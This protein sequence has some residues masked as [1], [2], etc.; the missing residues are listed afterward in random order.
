MRR[1]H[2]ALRAAALV[3]LTVYAPVATAQSGARW[4][5]VD[6]SRQ[7]RDT[8]PQRIRVQYAAGKLDVRGT[9]DPL[10]YAM[11]LRYDETRA[12]PLHRYDAEQRSALLGV[13]SLGRGLRAS[14]G[15]DGDETGELKLQ[16]PSRIPLELDLELGGTQ[17]VL[18]LGGLSLHSV[19]L[20]CGA[21]D[22]TLRFSAPN[23]TRMRDLEIDVGA[24]DFS[25]VNLGNA[26]ADQ[27]RLQG[28]IGVVDLDFG[29]TWTQDMTVSTRLAVGKLMLRVPGDVGVRLEVQRVA[30][31]FEHEGFTKRD[32]AWYS[33]NY[34]HAPRRLRLRAETFFGKIEIQRG[35][36]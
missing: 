14:S 35:T 6:L 17:S 32:D 10:L 29:G 7:L 13:E 21:T 2:A 27:I 5:S 34:D 28:G 22:A 23:R 26:N 31:G 19:R 33:E 1:I 15:D 36:R 16:V 25:A 18:E 4:R 3:A 11:H 30:A 9:S 20:E 8:L 12:I 24:A